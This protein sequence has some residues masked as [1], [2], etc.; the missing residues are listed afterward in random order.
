MYNSRENLTILVEHRVRK[1]KERQSVKPYSVPEIVN[2]LPRSEV[3]ICSV[4][5]F[6]H[7]NSSTAIKVAET[8]EALNAGSNEIDMVV[9][10]GKVLSEDWG[11]VSREIAAVNDIVA[12]R[13]CV[14]KVIFEND[15]VQDFHIIH[16][17]E[18][19]SEQRVAFVKA[20]TG[21]GFVKQV[22]GSYTYKGATDHHLKLI[23][24]HS[25]PSVQIAAAGGVRTLAD[26]LRVRSLGVTRVGTTATEAILNE[27]IEQLG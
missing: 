20:S 5:A 22:D 6:P 18:I 1:V 17:C 25:N 11:Y 24:K 26:L 10:V 2:V 15:Y 14:L 4:V 7:G 23:R 12:E 19:C 21:Y 13:G 8:K 9:N 16:L 27:A 3:G